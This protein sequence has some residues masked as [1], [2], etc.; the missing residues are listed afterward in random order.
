M[1]VVYIPWSKA[2]ELCYKLAIT[3]LDNNVYPNIVVAISRGGLV[4]AR[5]VSDVLGVDEL[6]VIKSRYWGIGGRLYEHPRVEEV[7]RALVESKDVLVIDEVVDTGETMS[8]VVEMLRSMGA[9]SVKTGVLHYKTTSRYIPDYYVE[10]VEKWVWIFYPWSF[11]ETLYAL[12]SK[13]SGDVVQNA[14]YI[15]KKLGAT[16]LYIDPLSII[17][18][19][20]RYQQGVRE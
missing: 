13:Q 7:K 10:K 1:E 15:L 5:I 8:R 17:R 6:V 20:S 9:R 12:A 14:F 11:I 2:I 19:L 4:P 3:I 18:S 16:E